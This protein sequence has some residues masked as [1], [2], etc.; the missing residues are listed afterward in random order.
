M[1]V[2]IYIY[3]YYKYYIYISCI[4]FRTLNYGNCGYIPLI[5]G[6]AGFIPSTVLSVFL[7]FRA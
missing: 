1:C 3:I 5:M 4:T 2:Y 7:G 6:N